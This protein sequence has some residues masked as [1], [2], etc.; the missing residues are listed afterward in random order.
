MT[1]AIVSF[2]R[3]RELTREIGKGLEDSFKEAREIDHQIARSLN[4]GMG[5][6]G[7][8]G[9]LP[10]VGRIVTSVRAIKPLSSLESELRTAL[11]NS[12]V[13]LVKVGRKAQDEK[14]RIAQL[15][16]IYDTAVQ[17]GWGSQ[18]F[19]R[20][21]E[22]N[23]DIDYTVNLNGS[24]IDMKDLFAE[25]DLRL[26]FDR[27]KD[28]QQE[29]VDWLKQHLNLSEQYL[30]SMHA[31]CFV[32]CEW[33]GGM[34]RSYFDLTQLRGGMEEIQRTLQNLGRGGTASITSQQA[35]RQYGTAYIN[36]MR[37]LM[38]GYKKMC[39]LKD[40]GSDGFRSSL[41]QLETDLNTSGASHRLETQP[42]QAHDR[43][44]SNPNPKREKD[45]NTH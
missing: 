34:T 9:R 22:A 43:L 15:S 16:E 35:L 13:S 30:E 33:V 18:E 14:K 29:Y 40:S 11:N 5:M 36:G 39:T 6:M 23:T 32:G 21:I 25:V 12:L 2:G 8:V 3:E 7:Y 17:E 45:D 44:L 20:F 41:R 38:Q 1:Q 37:S 4:H 24:Q 10:I 31:L 27:R 42:Y 28:K 19:I 26:S